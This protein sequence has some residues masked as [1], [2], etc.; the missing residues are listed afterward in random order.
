VLRQDLISFKNFKCFGSDAATIGVFF[1][2][3]LQQEE[4]LQVGTTAAFERSTKKRV[5]MLKVSTEMP[6]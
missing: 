5:Y 6:F 2:N 1:E 3:R 4:Q